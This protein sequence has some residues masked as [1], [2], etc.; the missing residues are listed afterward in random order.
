MELLSVSFTEP[1]VYHEIPAIYEDLGL[2]D[3]SS[4]IQ[5]RFDF[6]YSLGKMQSSGHGSIRFYK[7]KG[8]FRIKIFEELPGFGPVRLQQLKGL[9]LE[10][11]KTT[12]IENIKSETEKR[13][14]YYTDFRN[15]GTGEE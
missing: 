7:Q 14:V 13:K 10:E 4:F 1:P 9:L 5:Q 12:F 3:L 15:P 6:V 8:D 2:P 11:V